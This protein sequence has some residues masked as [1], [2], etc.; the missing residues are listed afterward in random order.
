MESPPRYQTLR[1]RSAKDPLPPPAF[2]DWS[3]VHSSLA[4]ILTYTPATVLEV[5]RPGSPT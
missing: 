2:R 1:C 3:L 4:N 5:E